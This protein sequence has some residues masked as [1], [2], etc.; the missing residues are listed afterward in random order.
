MFLVLFSFSIQPY[1]FLTR[2]CLLQ[3]HNFAIKVY[4]RKDFVKMFKSRQVAQAYAGVAIVPDDEDMVSNF[5]DKESITYR[6][7]GKPW[8]GSREKDPSFVQ[9]FVDCLTDEAGIVFDWSA[10][11]GN[12]STPRSF[13]L[14]VGCFNYHKVFE[15][16]RCFCHRLCT[17]QSSPHRLGGRREDFRWTP[18]HLQAP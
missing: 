14:F 16:C 15:L 10:S 8:R 1:F 7:D 17:F 18:G 11:T 13:M 9:C 2:K 5:A 6:T 3:T 4:A 12:T